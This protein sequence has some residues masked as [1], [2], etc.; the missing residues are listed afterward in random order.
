MMP[1]SQRNVWYGHL[2]SVA[3]N[4]NTFQQQYE[5]S[6]QQ[7]VAQDSKAEQYPIGKGKGKGGKRGPWSRE[8]ES[9]NNDSVKAAIEHALTSIVL[10]TV[11]E[12]LSIQGPALVEGEVEPSRKKSKLMESSQLHVEENDLVDY[13]GRSWFT[14][15]SDRRARSGFTCTIPKKKLHSCLGHT[16]GISRL[17]FYPGT[18]HLL[19]SASMDG[20]AR[21]WDVYKHG[22]VCRSYKTPFGKGMRDI[23]FSSDG[24]H[25]LSA[26]FDGYM[27]Q[28][29]TE[30]GACVFTYRHQKSP[31]CITY[32]TGQEFLAGCQD[33][34]ILQLDLRSGDIV[35]EY[36]QHMGGINSVTMLDENRRFI[37]SSD[38]KTMR[39]WEYGIPV[40]IKMMSDPTMHSMPVVRP[41]HSE[42]Y[43]ACQS[44]DNKIVLYHADGRYALNKKKQFKGHNVAGYACGLEGSPDGAYVASGDSSGS[45]F[46]W[47]WKS[48]RIAHVLKN[49]HQGALMGLSW[50]PREE[51]MVATGG[52]DGA[53]H[54]WES[55]S[56]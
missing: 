37:S 39:V 21:L 19:L 31:L 54:L 4:E 56:A 5:S 55:R 9:V 14:A 30:T 16:K 46:I 48:S 6:R 35:Q 40:V 24:K 12:P 45:L 53:I 2:S 50:N 47:E 51:S 28:W 44:M 34:K 10:P 33:K 8:E 3:I 18:G 7:D 49:I 26:S 38:D 41:V 13:Q 11:S 42:K 20:T 23:S 27:R 22:E 52:W 43:L 15:P 32:S 1:V 17:L 36:A 29:D 25:F